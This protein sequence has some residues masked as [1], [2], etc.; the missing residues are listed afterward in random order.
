MPS[1]ANF[2]AQAKGDR[3]VDR[4]T[5]RRGRRSFRSCGG[6]GPVGAVPMARL[7]SGAV[8]AS[9]PATE[10]RG[11]ER[12]RVG[13]TLDAAPRSAWSGRI[14]IAKPF[15]L[16][17]GGQRNVSRGVGAYLAVG[18]PLISAPAPSLRGDP[19]E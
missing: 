17:A 4:R 6:T 12:R 19:E 11:K 2:I 5:D 15:I 9:Q 10:R 7:P 16:S 14:V 18:S 13:G 8:R 3:S 1:P